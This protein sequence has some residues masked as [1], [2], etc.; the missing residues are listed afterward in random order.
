MTLLDALVSQLID[1]HPLP[2]SIDYDW[3]VEVIDSRGA[4]AIK[5]FSDSQA[6]E[7]RAH[8]ERLAGEAITASIEI[9]RML[10]EPEF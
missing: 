9:E 2:W 3:C 7:L 10:N 6:Q 8:A 5:L 4:C 1:R